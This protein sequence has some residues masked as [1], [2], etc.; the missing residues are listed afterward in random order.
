VQPRRKAPRFIA[1]LLLLVLCLDAQ[2]QTAVT[3]VTYGTLT[4]NANITRGGITYLERTRTVSTVT[5]GIGDF[6]FTG[7]IATSVTFRRNTTAGNAN[8]TTIFYQIDGSNRD[9]GTY[10]PNTSE[11][12]LS[13]NLYQGVRNPFQNGTGSTQS[14]I[15]RIDFHF[16]GGYTVNTNDALVFFDLENTGNFG[17]G[18]RLAAFTA[19][20]GSGTPTAYANTGLLVAPDSFG[21]P[22]NNPQ[23]TSSGNYRRATFTNGDNLSG[24]ASGITGIGTLEL[25]GILIRFSDMGVSTGTTIQGF[26]LMAGDVNPTAAA[27]LVNWNDASYFPTNTSAAGAGY[28]NMDFMGFG[29]RI[30]RPVPEPSTYGLMLLGVTGAFLGWR[31]RRKS[32]NAPAV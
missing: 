22:V 1:L 15:E 12:F 31:R 8:N 30:A 9:Y 21:G 2:A 19:A 11:L 10:E 13:N 27:D 18:F 3:G 16:S 28:G 7:P 23:L 5:S 24:T 26:S 4:D 6:N 25:V 17:D 29:S 14:N 20:D 32:V